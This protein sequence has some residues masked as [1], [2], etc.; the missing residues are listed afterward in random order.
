MKLRAIIEIDYNNDIKAPQVTESALRQ[1]LKELLEDGSLGLDPEFD[2]YT[3]ETENA[4]EHI[5]IKWGKDDVLSAAEED[6]IELNDEEV[7][8]ILT[9]IKRR[10]DAEQ[11]VNWDVIKSTI[12]EFVRTTRD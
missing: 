12:A 11:G 6:D 10:H 4:E 2:S 8:K 9:V 1:E 7:K 5:L 3:L